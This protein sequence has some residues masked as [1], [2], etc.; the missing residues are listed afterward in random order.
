MVTGIEP[1]MVGMAQ[2]LKGAALDHGMA[3]L[4]Y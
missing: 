3:P 4:F 1:T 2:T